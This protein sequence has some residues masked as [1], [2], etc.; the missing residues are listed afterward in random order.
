MKLNLI[1]SLAIATAAFVAAPASAQEFKGTTTGCFGASCTPNTTAN[2][3]GVGGLTF[4]Q[5]SFDQFASNGFLGIGGVGE[6][7]GTF[8][9]GGTNLTYNTPFSLLVTFSL[10]AGTTP[11]SGLYSALVTGSVTNSNT[12]GVF[13]DFDNTPQNFTFNGGSF[14]F[15]VNDLSVNA[16]DT[17]AQITGV[18]RAVPEP[19]TW[20][21]MLLGFGA[22]G[23]TMRRRRRPALA[24]LA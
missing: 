23:M 13:V 4:T 20:A 14:S 19:A 22:I 15:S 24:Q 21:M 12:G 9:L 1:S 3:G 10:P 18:I 11:G 16:G 17:A 6:N 5:G 2:T 7:L 8:S